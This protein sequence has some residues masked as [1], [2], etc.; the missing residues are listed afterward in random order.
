MLHTQYST[1]D[2]DYE[3]SLMAKL[4]RG[5]I[6]IAQRSIL[7]LPTMKLIRCSQDIGPVEYDDL[8]E[9]LVYTARV[10]GGVACPRSPE[11]SPEPLRADCE[12]DL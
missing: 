4:E 10:H 2:L 1:P 11:S 5:H 6:K 12:T 9:E 8:L 7:E 3:V